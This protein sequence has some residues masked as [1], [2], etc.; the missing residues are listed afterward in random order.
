MK[1]SRRRLVQLGLG[2]A[3][4]GVGA[5]PLLARADGGNGHKF[6]F[7]FAIGGWDIAHSLAPGV[8][9]MDYPDGAET[10]EAGDLRFVSVPSQE[11]V[12][13][14]FATHG[15]RTCLLHGVEARSV[16][17][18]VCLRLIMTGDSLPG[19]DDWPSTLAA[20]DP[21]NRLLPALHLG[22][23]SYVARYSSSVVRTGTAGQLP[24]LLDGSALEGLG[25]DASWRG[26]EVQ[27]LE[28]EYL[29]LREE[30]AELA[31]G[32][33]RQADLAAAAAEMGSRL[34]DLQALGEE[35]ELRVG[36]GLSDR[37]QLAASAMTQGLSRTA[38]VGHVGAQGLSWDTHAANTPVQT[39]NHQELFEALDE[40]V[41][42]LESL[43]G[44]EEDALIDETTVVV[45]SEM[46]RYPR[47]NASDGK[48]HWTYTS[49]MLIGGGIRGG[50]M[51]GAYDEH[52]GGRPVDLS[53][54]AVDDA[55]GTRLLPGHVGATLLHLG[56]HDRPDHL[57]EEPITACLS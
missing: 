6:L 55:E 24:D 31:A 33:G 28:R 50:T 12:D 45:L 2:A 22:G 49:M 48:E 42:T 57:D 20:L 41:V 44:E 1:L 14:F 39:A 46:S 23:P 35:L 19:R 56:G 29:R 52:A 27:G 10:A 26:E 25:L 4:V 15:E 43:P 34:E 51:V 38:M 36:D 32:R 5:L 37:L 3:G 40:L 7:V 53:T 30:T 13:S 16:A 18:D 47:L 17:H 21:A 9:A 54:G 11:A 8:D